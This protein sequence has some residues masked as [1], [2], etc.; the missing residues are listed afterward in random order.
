M[1]KGYID[2]S[3][4]MESNLFTLSCLIGHTSM[5]LW[6]EWAW[7]DCIEKKNNRLRAE[8]R[9]ELSRFHAAHCWSLVRE[10]RGWSVPEQREFMAGPIKVFQRHPLAIIS[11]TVDL[12]DLT[13]EF[14]EAKDN[15]RGLAHVLL[16]THIM[17]YIAEKILIHPDTRM[18]KL[19]LSMTEV[20]T[21]RFFLRLSIT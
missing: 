11:Y 19:R 12:K 3:G 17:K 14:P 10:F 16:L 13:A 21:M 18:K 8:G 9:K 4:S 20:T 6:I 5:W 7:L 2:D 1:L 15:P